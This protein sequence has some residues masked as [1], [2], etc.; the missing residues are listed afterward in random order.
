MN[1]ELP[2]RKH[3]VHVPPVERHTS[4]VILFVTIGLQPRVA[5]LANAPFMNAFVLG[6]RDA[7]A[8][9]VGRY[10]IMPDHVH[11]FTQPARHP[12]I[13]IRAWASFLKRRITAQ[14][15]PHDWEWQG[16]VWDTQMRSGEHYRETWA[17]V[18]QNPVRQG[19]VK[20][21]DDWPWQGEVNVL[22]W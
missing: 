6:C 9:T 14:Y 7:D 19:L 11:L 13:G 8:W 1:Q 22:R 18:C 20:G 21:A 3:P 10:V 12:R 5:R 17:Y 4:P 2:Q 16:D 15:G